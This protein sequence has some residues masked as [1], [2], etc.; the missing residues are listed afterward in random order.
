MYVF[1][2]GFDKIILKGKTSEITKE[3]R[4]ITK[5][6]LLGFEVTE[7]DNEKCVVEEVSE[8]EEGK[9]NLI[10]GKVFMII[11]DMNELILRDL[12]EVL[13]RICLK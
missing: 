12:K 2:R 3:I 9:Y 1:R 5:D 13:L 8:P 6:L 7:R 11:K 10:L 4:N